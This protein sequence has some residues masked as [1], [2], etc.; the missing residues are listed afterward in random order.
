MIG[1]LFYDSSTSHGHSSSSHVCEQF[2]SGGNCAPLRIPKVLQL[3]GYSIYEAVQ[4]CL[5]PQY[6]HQTLNKASQT[7][8][9]KLLNPKVLNPQLLNPKLL[10]PKLL[11]PKPLNPKPLNPKLFLDMSLLP[12]AFIPS[13]LGCS[14]MI[15]PCQS[16]FM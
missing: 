1:F 10:N 13:C 7:L 3:L 2:S 12:S 6:F 15:F 9:P 11:N 8:N 16:F 4:D 14:S 5:H